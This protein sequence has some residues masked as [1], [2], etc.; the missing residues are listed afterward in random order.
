MIS[1]VKDLAIARSWKYIFVIMT[2]S[3]CS[4]A[5]N[6]GID[7]QKLVQ[8]PPSPEATGFIEY[9]NL[10]VNYHLGRPNIAVP[11][12]AHQGREMS[13]PITLSYNASGIK[14][15]QLASNVG[16]GWTLVAGGAITRIKLGMADDDS[17][18]S[19]NWAG[20]TEVQ[21]IIDYSDSVKMEAGYTLPISTINRL[22]AIQ[23]G[24]EINH[25]DS[26]ADAY[27]LSTSTGLSTT[28]YWDYKTKKAFSTDDPT[29]KIIADTVAGGRPINWTVI[30][31][32]GTK[33][34]FTK[35][36][37]TQYTFSI[38]ANEYESEYVSAWFLTKITSPNRKDI[39][40]FNY[41]YEP[42]WEQQEELL[43]ITSVTNRPYATGHTTSGGG[44]ACPVLPTNEIWNNPSFYKIRQ[45]T[46]SSITWNGEVIFGL[47]YSS[48]R[49]DLPGAKE[50]ASATVYKGFEALK[51]INFHYSYFGDVN[52]GN[53]SVRLKLD[54]LEQVGSYIAPSL[55][56]SEK[57]VWRFEYDNPNLVPSRAD[58]G[59]DYWGYYNG[60]SNT[61]LVPSASWGSVDFLG[62]DRSADITKSV[63]GMLKKMYFPTGGYNEFFYEG[64][65][66]IN[67]TETVFT[68]YTS[69]GSVTAGN[70]VADPYG[71]CFGSPTTA[72]NAM[73]GTIMVDNQAKAFKVAISGGPSTLADGEFVGVYIFPE[74]IEWDHCHADSLAN[75]GL[76]IRKFIG[77]NTTEFPLDTMS[78][79]TYRYL[80][81][82]SL[83]NITASLSYGQLDTLTNSSAST[84]VGGFR[85]AK[86][87][88]KQADGTVSLTREFEYDEAIEQ[89]PL[90]FMEV[91][92]I[93]QEDDQVADFTCQTV[94]RY[95]N[96]R[97]T[98]NGKDMT[99]GK[100]TEKLTDNGAAN[101]YTVYKFTNSPSLLGTYPIYTGGQN[102]GKLIETSVYNNNDE[103]LKKTE[104]FYSDPR[105]SG[106][107]LGI[108]RVN[109]MFMEGVETIV[110]VRVKYNNGDSSSY[111]YI[112]NQPASSLPLACYQHAC[113][114]GTWTKYRIRHY[115]LDAYFTKLDR[116][117]VTEYF[118]GDSIVTDVAYTYD[119][120]THF[121]VTSQKVKDSN[122]DDWISKYFYPDDVDP[123]PVIGLS[124]LDGPDI[125]SDE[126]TA[127]NKLKSNHQINTVIQTEKHKNNIV[128]SRQ[129]TNY[130]L[131]SGDLVLPKSMETS[132]ST[133]PMVME[134]RVEY[135]VYDAQG[136]P[137]EVSQE[138]GSHI[139]YI[140]GYNSSLP[141]IQGMNI[142]HSNLQS[143]VT[144]ALSNMVNIPL[145]V[146]D[147]E[148]LLEYIGPMTAQGQID[149]WG[150]FNSK[151]R[152]HSSIT[153]SVM[154]TSMAYNAVKGML[155][156]T[157]PN[158]LHTFYEYD[159]MGRLKRVRDNDGNVIQTYK[160]NFKGQE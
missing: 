156:Q 120:T 77:N 74:T 108:D 62:A 151:L 135:H 29:L 115:N 84:T 111:N 153:T 128:L 53:K 30:D 18:A 37:L 113:Q 45:Q 90:N 19:Q 6:E 75:A 51:E 99:Y 1:L 140:W 134:K 152:E 70:D 79:G 31:A 64:H 114:Q 143:A 89:T 7:M 92:S 12:Y 65:D 105:L 93:R 119:E 138:G 13:L 42:Y 160:Y 69:L 146:T 101:G 142:D 17:E 147:L 40:E 25:G 132:K 107:L 78:A 133:D 39:Y 60:K 16:L 88:S 130:E 46:L 72:P 56:E 155:A 61:S 141:V 3:Y 126:H 110:G 15:Q 9:G 87:Q 102:L 127:V 20:N 49:L 5:Q 82:N 144:W 67:I 139:S 48:D 66:Q 96:N 157:D 47:N 81:Y 94:Y 86:I 34:E 57:Q 85:I 125:E 63:F 35:T 131:L 124:S 38:D 150:N 68:N 11:V 26:Q 8:I 59:V 43:T 98:N 104:N 27:A 23:D 58:L 123:D 33:Y 122:G 118:D 71:F 83:S 103:L 14:T 73:T 129:R 158:G 116:T 4:F 154:L 10:D 159:S 2:F 54:S 76:A 36:E 95:S 21:D 97:N 55:T 148:T 22:L 109:N 28:I 100:V 121:Q 91:K 149:A 112:P 52:A 44:L 145:G 50:I 137:L 136:N 41:N 80:I 106:N 32:S 24:I 117:V